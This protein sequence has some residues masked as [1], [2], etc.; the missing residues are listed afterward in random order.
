MQGL[1]RFMRIKSYVESRIDRAFIFSSLIHFRDFMACSALPRYHSDHLPL[2]VSLM[3]STFIGLRPFHFQF[4]EGS[5][6]T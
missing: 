4:F 1:L 6:L 5:I 2:L 3:A